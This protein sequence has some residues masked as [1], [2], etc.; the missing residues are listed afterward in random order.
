ML[1]SVVIK[2]DFRAQPINREVYDFI[3]DNL[4]DKQQPLNIFVDLKKHL[5]FEPQN[6]VG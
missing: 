4:N 6:F 1:R 5:T 3:Y 2:R